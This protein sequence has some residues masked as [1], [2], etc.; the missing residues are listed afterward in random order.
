MENVVELEIGTVID[1]LIA[2][3]VKLQRICE[4]LVAKNAE[5]DTQIATQQRLLDSHE[6]RIEMLEVTVRPK[7]KFDA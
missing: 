5:K 6:H 2:S 7:G 3:Q 4:A 1:K